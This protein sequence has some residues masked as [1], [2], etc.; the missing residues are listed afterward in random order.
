MDNA[1]VGTG[2]KNKLIKVST[3]KFFSQ[4]VLVQKEQYPLRSNGDLSYQRVYSIDDGLQLYKDS[5]PS[6]ALCG[7]FSATGAPL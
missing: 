4:I 6:L 1:M 5:L 7:T 3:V 2:L